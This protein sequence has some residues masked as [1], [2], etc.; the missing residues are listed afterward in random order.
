[1]KICVLTVAV[2]V[3]ATIT[4]GS[5]S[6]HMPTNASWVTSANAVCN[7][8]NRQIEHLPRPSSLATEIADLSATAQIG[9]QGTADLSAIPRPTSE[10]L[11]IAALVK[12]ARAGIPL[13]HEA[14]T[15][16]QKGDAALLLRVQKAAQTLNDESNALATTLGARICAV[17]PQPSG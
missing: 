17:N 8:E 5:A 2:A 15:A 7:S 4:A 16:F 9:T 13:I 1:M 6:A 3:F 11:S 14:I 10:R 12:D